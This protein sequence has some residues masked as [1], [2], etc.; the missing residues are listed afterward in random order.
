MMRLDPNSHAIIVPVYVHGDRGFRIVDMVLD[1]GATYVT[2]PSNVAEL[3]GYK[4][5]ES[6]RHVTFLT[7]SGIENAPLITVQKIGVLGTE[8]NNVETL[9]MTLPGEN[10]LRGLLGL[11]FLKRFDMDVH[12]KQRVLR[13]R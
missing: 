6:N 13:I 9:C 1:T 12:F 3:L 11:S 5:A 4:P 10:R 8:A 7:A 2:F